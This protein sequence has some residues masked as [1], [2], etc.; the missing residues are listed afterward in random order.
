MRLTVG[1]LP[2]AVYWRRRGVVLVGLA[3]VVLVVSYACGGPTQSNGAPNA[4][5][6]SPTGTADPTTSAPHPT[7]PSTS[8]SPTATA[9]SLVTG[10]ATGPC[11][12]SEIELTASAASTSVAPAQEVLFTIKIKNIADRTCDRDVGADAQELKLQDASGVV[13]SSD[14]CNPRHGTDVRS[15]APA[16]ELTFSLTWPGT[17]S[18]SGTGAVNCAAGAPAPTSGVYEL[19]ARLDKKVSAPFA[20]K[21]GTA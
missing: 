15:F 17:R 4:G 18:K 20:L 2:A 14:D 5:G 16:K 3:M 9:F 11:T 1:P 21:I 10:A 7:L 13:W 12:D 6:S 8:A 19:I